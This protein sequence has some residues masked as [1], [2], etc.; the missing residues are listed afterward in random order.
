MIVT[1]VYKAIELKNSSSADPEAKGDSDSAAWAWPEAVLRQHLSRLVAF[2]G[3]S[4]SARKLDLLN[5]LFEEAL[6]G[7]GAAV[8]Q[9]RI[10]QD[11]YQLGINY[12][13]ENDSLIR[14]H[15]SHLRRALK[16]YYD[17]PGADDPVR[18]QLAAGSYHLGFVSQAVALAA[19]ERP[20]VGIL[21]FKELGLKGYWRHLPAVLVEELC[22]VIHGQDRLKYVGPFSRR[23]LEAEGL[24]PVQLGT[25]YPV[26]YVLDGSVER[27]ATALVLR[28][29]LLDGN[30]GA[31]I[32][33]G[34]EEL[35]PEQPDM[36]EF[37]QQILRRLAA[38]IGEDC[39]VVS[40][41]LSSLAR[42]KPANALSVYEAVLLGRMYLTD[43]DHESLPRVLETLR[44][45]AI[46][47][48]QESA[49]SATLAVI[50][51]SLGHEPRWP[52][53]PPLAEIRDH[54]ERAMR[55]APQDPW[56][57]LASAF[58]ATV[59]QQRDELVRIACAVE[60]DGEHWPS[61]LLGGVGLLLCYQ[62]VD[63]DRGR[64]LIAKAYASNPHY[65]TVLHVALA[66]ASFGDGDFESARRELDALQ[67]RW[68]L[69]EP[70]LRGAM[71]AAE[72]DFETARREWRDVIAAF[73]DFARDGARSF[74]FAWHSDYL[75]QIAAAMQRAGIRI[76]LVVRD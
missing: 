17:G 40:Q 19:G 12:R 64:R 10:A 66:L 8:T 4:S 76:E 7:R 39:G 16:A 24:D 75:A 41:H 57:I 43:F 50:L 51:A 25:R 31:L 18:L 56:S 30:S 6:V 22:G 5:Y 20:V 59:H 71:A 44:R 53:D 15:A 36:A 58:S 33:S 1:L 32:W 3:I 68:G 38:A 73:P 60:R 26:D 65:P 34:R 42:V 61:M 52:G 45:A 29:R 74:G 37:Q 54:A 13:G 11:C 35:D 48:P 47:E 69:S 72:G 67:Y 63:L 49:P 55:L 62:K 70:L 9:A 2:E 21:E 46:Q 27:T 23:L 28:T 14:V